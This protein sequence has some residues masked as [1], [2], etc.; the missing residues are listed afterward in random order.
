MQEQNFFAN[1]FLYFQEKNSQDFFYNSLIYLFEHNQNGALGVVLN[2]EVKIQETKIFESMKIKT[3][4]NEKMVLNGGPVD[5]NK[6][7]V[8]HNDNNLQESLINKDGLN[9]SSSLDLITQIA[10][11]RFGGYYKFALG[12][13]GWDAGQ[14]DNEIK[15]NNWVLVKENPEFIF[16]TSPE[17]Y[18]KELSIKSGFEID[19]ILNTGTITKH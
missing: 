5:I 16:Q 14:L 7:F 12:Y 4:P 1:Y 9:L 13:C 19:R 18:V 2:K 11:G 8:I 15:N 10:K 17:N 6:L 3:K